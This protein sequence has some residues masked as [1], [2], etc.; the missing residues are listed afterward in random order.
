V[1]KS[2]RVGRGGRRNGAGRKP[3]PL[4][5]PRVVLDT[6]AGNPAFPAT[7]RVAAALARVPEFDGR[8]PPMGDLFADPRAVLAD[9]ASD[10]NQPATARVAAA[11]ALLG[12]REDKPDTGGGLLAEIDK[13]TF[14]LISLKRKG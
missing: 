7:A 11:K 13:R 8:D 3:K 9:I 14:A 10:R 4:V 5:D 6:V 1:T 2:R 12:L